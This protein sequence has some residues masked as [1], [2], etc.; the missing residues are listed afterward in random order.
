MKISK[1][2]EIPLGKEKN[3]ILLALENGSLVVFGGINKPI[4]LD[5]QN[6]HISAAT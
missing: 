5:Y 1:M 3:C 6:H 2:L 4:I